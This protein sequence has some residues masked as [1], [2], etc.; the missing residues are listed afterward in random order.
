[1][2]VGESGSYISEPP[3]V[4]M[5]T[6]LTKSSTSEEQMKSH[7]PFAA[8]KGKI[9]PNFNIDLARRP[10]FGTNGARKFNVSSNFYKCNGAP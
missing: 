10:G 6:N 8:R 3:P 5:D 9:A 4:V 1:M 2:D 7:E